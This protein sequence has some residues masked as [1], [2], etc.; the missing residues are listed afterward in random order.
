[1]KD[2][3]VPWYRNQIISLDSYRRHARIK[4]SLQFG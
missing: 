3:N 1:M 2:D 4:V